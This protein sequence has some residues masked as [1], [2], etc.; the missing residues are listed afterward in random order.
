MKRTLLAVLGVVVATLASAG[1]A[2]SQTD[3]VDRALRDAI[4]AGARTQNVII[5]VKPGYLAI[6]RHALEEHGDLIKADHESIAAVS[7]EVHADDIGELALQPWVE[8]VSLDAD[9]FASRGDV[10]AIG[11]T[12]LVGSALSAT[13][14]CA[15]HPSS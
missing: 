9:V 14:Q 11:Q 8:G 12:R 3:K 5:S 13:A 7:A 15:K 2:F 1:S 6:V 4:R 10:F